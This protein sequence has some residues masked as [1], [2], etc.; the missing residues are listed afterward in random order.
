[1]AR[2][3]PVEQGT[4]PV[5]VQVSLLKDQTRGVQVQTGQDQSQ[6]RRLIVATWYPAAPGPQAKPADLADF[7]SLQDK[8][9]CQDKRDCEFLKATE[10]S[11]LRSTYFDLFGQDDLPSFVFNAIGAPKE[12]TLFEKIIHTKTRAVWDAP[13][14]ARRS[15]PVVVYHP[16]YASSYFENYELCEKLASQGFYVV[17]S[18][19]FAQQGSVPRVGTFED[20]LADLQYL[21]A[22]LSQ[23]REIDFHRRYLIGYSFGAQVALAYAAMDQ[24]LKGVVSLDSTLER[25]TL[26]QRGP[27]IQAQYVHK[28]RVRSPVLF[29][30]QAQGT[31]LAW[32]KSFEAAPRWNIGLRE[33]GH[34]MFSSLGTMTRG[35]SELNASDKRRYY[36]QVLEQTLAFLAFASDQA[37]DYAPPSTSE[38]LE[39]R[40]H[41][42]ASE[43]QALPSIA[44]LLAQLDAS[45]PE[46][47]VTSRC[48]HQGQ[49][50]SWTCAQIVEMLLS[51]KHTHQAIAVVT[52]ALARA[53]SDWIIVKAAG[54]GAIA[55]G[56]LDEA[57]SRYRKAI[58]LLEKQAQS[59]P[60][61]ALKFQKDLLEA[62][63]TRIQQARSLKK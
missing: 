23:K 14:L 33:G 26:A 59:I 29:F 48:S 55:R 36:E 6:A 11:L 7:L 51:G 22:N 16:G 45:S 60:P 43:E 27:H 18:S 31:D 20:S 58:A 13:M 24:G 9:P 8:I 34:D 52:A 57:E 61:R 44:L 1:M 17:S 15:F 28:D 37:K 50:E 12:K 40:G 41:L 63:L 49:L 30:T 35:S 53:P 10:E 25:R 5:G 38:D 2:F 62:D 56:D 3:A 19:F 47:F 54:R 4:Y 39:N 32:M 46:A 42:Q 21:F